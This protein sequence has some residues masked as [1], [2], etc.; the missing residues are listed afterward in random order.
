MVNDCQELIAA[1]SLHTRLHCS[2]AR[3]QVLSKIL[4]YQRVVVQSKMAQ[5]VAQR[6]GQECKLLRLTKAPSNT[7]IWSNSQL[8]V[9]CPASTFLSTTYFTLPQKILQTLT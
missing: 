6:S 8:S 5:I 7:E 2:M 9:Q 1:I 4:S 3:T